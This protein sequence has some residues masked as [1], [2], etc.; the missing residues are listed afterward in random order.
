MGRWESYKNIVIQAYLK[1]NMFS[2]N[3]N[4]LDNVEVKSKYID[5]YDNIVCW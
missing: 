1:E 3:N 5:R 4:E 2:I